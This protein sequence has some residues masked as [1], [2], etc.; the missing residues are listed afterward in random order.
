MKTLLMLTAAAAVAGSAAAA[1]IKAGDLTLKDTV[2][3]AVGPGVP[4]TAAYLTI[5]NGGAKAD[6]LL[7]ASCDCSKSVEIH[8]SHV[9]NGMA[10]MMPSGPLAIP[11][12]G[13]ARFA[14]GGQHLMVTGLKGALADGAVQT[15]TLRFEHAGVV[16]AAFD[17][18]SRVPVGPAPAMSMPMSH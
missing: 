7:A 17:V 2:V 5:S 1:E 8:I 3:R 4:N 12:G 13:S 16:K 15:I 6:K 9:M 18:R 14:P 11:A 10:M